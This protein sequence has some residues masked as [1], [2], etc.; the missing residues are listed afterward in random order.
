MRGSCLCWRVCSAAGSGC[1]N[2]VISPGVGYGPG[3]PSARQEQPLIDVYFDGTDHYDGSVPPTE[4]TAAPPQPAKEAFRKAL[5]DLV[6]AAGRGFTTRTGIHQ[7]IMDWKRGAHFPTDQGDLDTVV[8]AAATAS[9]QTPEATEALVARF[10]RLL[11]QAREEHEYQSGSGPAKEAFREAFAALMN[12]AGRGFAT[13]TGFHYKIMEWKSGRRLPS[14]QGVLDKVVRAAATASGKSPR[15]QVMKFRRLLRRAG[16]GRGR[17]GWFRA[18]PVGPLRD[19]LPRTGYG[20]HPYPADPGMSGSQWTQETSQALSLLA[21]VP[22][23]P[24]PVPAAASPD[25]SRSRSRT[26]RRP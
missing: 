7:K 3:E 8:R 9:G 22:A 13:R 15:A 20:G 18:A 6:K 10:R 1:C 17:K 4:S 11:W 25:R 2:A 26:W 16:G 21:E 23:D 5:A 19:A 24:N 14:D 12:V